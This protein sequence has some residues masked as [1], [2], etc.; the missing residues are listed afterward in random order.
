MLD[1]GKPCTRTS[2]GAPGVPQRRLNTVTSFPSLPAVVERHRSSVLP[3]CHSAKMS[4]V[5]ASQRESRLDNSVLF[6]ALLGALL[7]I[8]RSENL[9]PTADRA[10]VDS[11]AAQY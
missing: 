5:P 2:A 1:V 11:T 4:K 8:D 9:Q 10:L 7:F 3:F 6:S